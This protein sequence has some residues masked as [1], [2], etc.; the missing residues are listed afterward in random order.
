MVYFRTNPA[1]N[2]GSPLRKGGHGH[3]EERG[4]PGGTRGPTST[5]RN[6]C[7]LGSDAGVLLGHMVAWPPTPEEETWQECGTSW[8]R[9]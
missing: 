8:T 7:I 3:Q 5:T 9:Q 1:E 2:V 6:G 4:F